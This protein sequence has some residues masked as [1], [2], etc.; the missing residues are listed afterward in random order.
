MKT[1]AHTLTQRWLVP[2]FGLLLIITVW[3][4]TLAELTQSR[5]AADASA[6]E[7]S[8]NLLNYYA[9]YTERT[10]EHL[11]QSAGIIKR[12]YEQGRTPVDLDGLAASGLLASDVARI[13]TIID[14]HGFVGASTRIPAGT[15]LGDQERFLVHRGIDSGRLHVS[16]PFLPPTTE[17]TLV[18]LSRRLNHPDGSF[19]GVVVIGVEPQVLTG[20]SQGSELGENGHLALIG[21]DGVVRAGRWGQI[22]AAEREIVVQRLAQELRHSDFGSFHRASSV[23]GV[24]RFVA[25]RKLSNYPLVVSVGVANATALAGYQAR[26]SFLLAS[27]TVATVVLVM[28]FSLLFAM[29]DAMRRSKDSAQRVE[30]RYRAATEGSLDAFVMLTAVRHSSGAICDFRVFD[31]NAICCRLLKLHKTQAVGRLVSELPLAF[32]AGPAVSRLASV[33]QSQATVEEERQFDPGTAPARWVRQQIVP[34]GDLLAISFRDVTAA[35]ESQLSLERAANLDP[36]TGLPNRHRFFTRLSTVLDEGKLSGHGV[37]LLLIDMD[38]FK[39]LNDVLGHATGDRY[40]VRLARRIRR[41]LRDGQE[42]FRPGGDEFGVLIEGRDPKVAAERLAQRIRKTFARMA[43]VEK[44]YISPSA[45]I[46]ISFFPEHADTAVDL[47]RSAELAMYNAKA[48]GKNTHCI[49]TVALGD[50]VKTRVELERQLRDALL[51]NE[52]TLVYQPKLSLGE[53]RISGFEALIRWRQ[54]SG[55]VVSPARFIPLAE[56][57]GLIVPLGEWVLRQACA[58][59]H[60]W[61]RLGHADLRIAVNVSARQFKPEFVPVVRNALAEFQLQPH[62]LELELTESLIMSDPQGACE[63]IQ[64]LKRLGVSLSIDDF[65]TG[66]SSLAYLKRFEVDALKVDRSFVTDI[67]QDDDACTIAGAIVR[68]AHALSIK[69]IA[70][71]VETQAQ[72]DFLKRLGCDEIQGYLISKPVAA[73]AAMHLVAA[74]ANRKAVPQLQLIHPTIEPLRPGTP[75]ADAQ[76]RP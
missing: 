24:E 22:T 43:E 52:F 32:D 3:V 11:D 45:S 44:G 28:F 51:R 63:T 53:N 60:D 29:V 74:E 58:Q 8:Q 70:E 67:P 20:D 2:L 26:R 76:T 30:A 54:P 55:E 69:V 48:K 71:G 10:I 64:Q 39:R 31:L 42:L 36:L 50:E 1:S 18:A 49:Y 17:R 61:A 7:R 37:S 56:A 6:T 19:A 57:T 33:V 66:Y 16:S 47:L 12:Q 13:T 73:E 14:E 34:K 38:D 27:A 65:G 35:R 72:R 68:M 4:V 75:Q 41:C 25:Y 40:L 23:D 59:L 62:Q 5:H 21:S 9:S 15:Y 46:G